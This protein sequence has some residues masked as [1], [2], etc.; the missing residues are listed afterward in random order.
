MGN[1]RGVEKIGPKKGERAATQKVGVEN[2][3]RK[4]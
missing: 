4:E 2:E 3:G 1:I